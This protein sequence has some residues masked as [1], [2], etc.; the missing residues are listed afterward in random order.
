M[1]TTDQTRRYFETRL[2]GQ[3]FT[4][5]GD[6]KSTLCPFHKD[7]SPSLSVNFI[8]RTWNCHAGCGGGGILDFEQRISRCDHEAAR[9]NVS[10]IVGEAVFQSNAAKNVVAKYSYIDREGRIVAIKLRYEPKNFGWCRPDG[11]G[12]FIHNTIGITVPLYHFR[13]LVT[14]R[15]V[16]VTEGE[17]DADRLL[18][19]I[20]GKIAAGGE[21]ADKLKETTTTTP[22]YGAA[23]WRDQYARSFADKYVTILPDNDD[24]GQKH[25]QKIAASIHPYA[26]GVRVLI[27]P[28]LEK[29]GDVSDYL[30]LRSFDELLA[31]VK[32]TPRWMPPQDQPKL[33]VSVPKF[34][35]TIPGS[36]DWMIEKVI[37]RGS[38]GFIAA[39]PKVGKS[40]LAAELAVSLALGVD[41]IGFKIPRPVRVALISREDNPALTGWRL[42]H[43]IAGKWQGQDPGPLALQRIE[44]N[45]YINSRAQSPQLL[46]DNDEQ[47]AELSHALKQLR[48]EFVLFDVFNIL[49]IADEN[50]NSAMRK[51]LA[52]LSELQAETGASIGAIHH[53][54][55]NA[56]DRS[57]TQR[58]RGAGAISGW[59]EWLIGIALMNDS[60]EFKVR[61]V[62]F[63]I[64]ADTPPEPV[65][66]TINSSDGWS[67]LTRVDYTKTNPQRKGPTA[68]EYLQQ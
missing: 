13:E 48:T 63:D 29:H 19:V 50:D 67:K 30:E 45:F 22:P 34:V 24:V 17:K 38:N 20:K 26:A 68:A 27:L 65:H 1:L 51:V 49:H 44:E 6:E 40:W 57:L 9:E 11:K 53:F 25:A 4:G 42:K 37:E 61:R 33:L 5:A 58:L 56:D 47:M 3:R 43:L 59:A 35:V 8:K 54:N 7:Q 21:G 14:A 23:K 55:K 62:E 32:R 16:F 46:I 31:E 18:T 64:K 28:G 36:I 66:F 2:K 41:C 52:R 12:G 10:Q 15:S 60:E 39:N